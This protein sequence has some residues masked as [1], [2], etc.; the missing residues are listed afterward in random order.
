M[1]PQEG[2]QARPPRA[3]TIEQFLYVW[4]HNGTDVELRTTDGYWYGGKLRY[5]YSKESSDLW[6]LLVDD[7]NQALSE[8]HALVFTIAD[9]KDFDGSGM[10]LV[11]GGWL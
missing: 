11:E 8:H 7:C 1:Y 5:G 6:I 9:V 4:C 2:K 10:I 3:A